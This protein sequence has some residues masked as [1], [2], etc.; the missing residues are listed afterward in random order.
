MNGEYGLSGTLPGIH[1]GWTQERIAQTKEFKQ[2][3]VIQKTNEDPSEF[4][5][6]T[7]Q[8]FHRY[9]DINLEDSDNSRQVNLT[10]IQQNIPDIKRKLEKWDAVLGMTHP[11]LVDVT[12]K[13]FS[14]REK[15]KQKPDTTC[16]IG[17]KASIPE[18]PGQASGSH[19]MCLLHRGRPLEKIAAQK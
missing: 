11:Q 7:Y 13:V 18:K 3:P 5:E 1:L 16:G 14:G 6:C 9:I 19:P 17:R 2:N 4:S 10:S 12:F 15:N 8:A